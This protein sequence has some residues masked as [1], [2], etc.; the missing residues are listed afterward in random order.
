MLVAPIDQ[1]DAAV[2]AK[3]AHHPHQTQGVFKNHQVFS[4]DTRAHRCTIRF[5][6]FLTQAHR[7]PV[8][9]HELAHGSIAFNT[10]DQLVFFFGHHGLG[11]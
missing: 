8:A 6:H 3:F 11:L 4:Q 5:G 9:T 2:R 1:G 7:L 10:G